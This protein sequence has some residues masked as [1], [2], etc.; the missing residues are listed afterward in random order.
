MNQI[1]I[2]IS[3]FE[4]RAALLEGEKLTEFFIQ[5]NEQN[6][7][8]GNIYKAKVANV[9]PGMESAFLDIGTQKN[10]FLHVRDLREYEGKYLNGVE[11]SNRPIEDI[12]SVGD[13]IIVQVVKE[14][15]GD[16][17]ARV[18]THYTI[19]G[20]YLVLMPND[21]H[22]AISQ[23]I[24]DPKER[25]RL[26][27]TINN[28]K[29]NEMGIIIRTAAKD[30]NNLHFEKEIKYLVKKWKDIENSFK[31]SKV[32]E[33]LYQDNDMVTRTVRDVFS[34]QIDEL[35]IDD[36]E[37]YWEIVDYV[38]AFSD[39]TFKTKVKLF[40]SSLHIFDH[41]NVTKELETALNERVWL[42]CGGY[43]I[44][45][46]TEALISIDVNTGK[47]TGV[48]NLEETV[49]ETNVEAAV[50]IAI[51]L[52][53]RNLSGIIII[54]FIDMKVEK[55]K[56]KVVEVLGESLKKDRIKNNI[57]HFTDLGLVEMTRK[58]QGSPLAKYYQKSCSCC[59]GTGTVKSKESIILDIMREIREVA[60]DD[61]IRLIRLTTSVE[62]YDF[63]CETY[64][65]FITGYLKLRKKGF[66]LKK[67][68]KNEEKNN[69]DYEIVME[70]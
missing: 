17:G 65:E 1:I 20:K 22:I 37:R 47:N 11:N 26:E 40:E 56:L 58:R 54:D 33:I 19:P 2:S 23:K 69:N 34:N 38:K 30:K 16:K 60:E 14:P 18:T 61:D 44:I 48:T 53:L 62:L 50:E 31:K 45:Q 66:V 5:R 57:I 7:I 49:V 36:E 6:L 28:I 15:R 35:I 63:I 13:E 12:L 59:D 29:P 21:S 27:T 25:E 3:D 51:Q 42:D 39:N 70:M 10:A 64:I 24:K 52:R 32:G 4:E 55:D 43:L 9:L 8:N 41:Y 46:K 68:K 67:N